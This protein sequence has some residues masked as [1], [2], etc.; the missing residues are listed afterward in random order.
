ML[1]VSREYRHC[2]LAAGLSLTDSAVRCSSDPPSRSESGVVNDDIDESE[3]SQVTNIGGLSAPV[4]AFQLRIKEMKMEM[5]EMRR[6][7]NIS[8]GEKDFDEDEVRPSIFE[9]HFVL[10]TFDLILIVYTL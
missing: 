10:P 2:R 4:D 9:S 3:C 1:D 5:N 8:A 6:T 7:H